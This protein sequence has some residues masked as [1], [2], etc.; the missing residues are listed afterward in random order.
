M[1]NGWIALQSLVDLGFEVRV[2]FQSEA[3]L[4]LVD[5]YE[6]SG[7][8]GGDK[9]VILHAWEKGIDEALISAY[10]AT[11]RYLQQ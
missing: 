11:K 1:I 9:K 7:E 3:K 8:L 4:H 5:V 6:V 10:N 2:S